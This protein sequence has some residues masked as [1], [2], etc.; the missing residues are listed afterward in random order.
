MTGPTVREVSEDEWRRRIAAARQVLPFGA[1]PWPEVGLAGRDDLTPVPLAVRVPGAGELLLPVFRR[2]GRRAQLGCFG[3]GMAH[4][5]ADWAGGA[6]PDFEVLAALVGTAAGVSAVS[7]LLPPAG[8]VAELDRIAGHWRSSEGRATYLL[9]A[10]GGADAVWRRARGSART[11]V[12]RAAR[13]GLR[14]RPAADADAVVVA[15]LYRDTMAR[16]GAGAPLGEPHFRT[17]LAGGA[18]GTVAAVA[19]DAAGEAHAAAVFA[20]HADTAYHL[21]QVT[22]ADGRRTNAG[23]LAFWHALD[24]LCH[25]G[26]STVD[27]GA[28]SA[29]G[30][31]FFKT[32]WGG[33]ARP[34]RRIDWARPT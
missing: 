19:A 28:A 10:T 4:P 24:R 15:R 34:T 8:A 13:L 32:S 12:R 6:L 22:S 2:P 33:R 23:Q 7:T 25:D 11:A 26:V 27:L 1:P 29:E 14:A 3:Y 18:A 20:R 5:A 30:Q 17:L 9:D 16:N 21:F 31:E